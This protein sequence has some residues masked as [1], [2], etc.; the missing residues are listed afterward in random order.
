MT[1][2]QATAAIHPYLASLELNTRL[3]RNCL[4]GVDRDTAERRLSDRSNNI[5][6]LACHLVDARHYLAGLLGA[7]PERPFGGVLDDA[8][9][10]D[11]LNELPPPADALTAWAAISELLAERLAALTAADLTTEGPGKPFPLAD[12]TLAGALNFLLGHESYHLGQMA[13][14]RKEHGLPAMTYD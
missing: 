3:L 13:L 7:K 8:R 12:D 11:D 4:A 10:I 14:L 1:P 5:A 2:S 6:F 9:S